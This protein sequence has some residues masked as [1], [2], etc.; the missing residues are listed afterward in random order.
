MTLNEYFE[1]AAGRGVLATSD[2]EGHVD[3]A[4]YA[5]PYVQDEETVTFVMADRL[6]HRNLQSN[7]HAVYLFMEAGDEFV[8]KRLH[9]TK[10]EEQSDGKAVPPSRKTTPESC[11]SRS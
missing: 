4:V 8:G 10:V 3:A 11:R 1:Q 6:S 5:R 9:L 7:P 2:A